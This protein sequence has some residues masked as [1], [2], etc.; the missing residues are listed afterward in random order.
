MGD[1][2]MLQ[3]RMRELVS[4]DICLAF[5]GGVDSSLLLKVAAD[6]A[7]ETGKKVYAVTFDSRLHPSCDLRIARQVAG[8]LGGIHQVM[9]VDELEQ[10]EIRMN[11]VNRCYL[12]K[13]HLFMTLKKLAGEKGVRRILDGTNEDDMHV[14][15][16][17]IR[18]L[19]ELGII[20]PLAELHITK[21]AVKGM[22][23]E[24]GISVASRPS[25]PCMATRLPYNTRIDYDVLD[26]IAQGEA[27]L[28]DALPG[29]V[30]L[31]LHGGIARL[32]V[33][34]EAFAR[35]LDRRA[36]VVRRL[37]GLGFT[38][39]TLDLEGFRSG[40]M[41]VGITEVHGSADPSGGVPL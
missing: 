8:E 23:S 5:S 12:C 36:D 35:L 38:Y 13:R 37:K 9:E 39:V 15:R 40:S 33:D 29:N 27:Y 10:E 25:T 3:A 31:R 4:E 6:A 2:E 24:Y 32:E 11:P 21:E 20:S 16:P 18:A 30:R 22:A 14:Y 19:K 17:G 41:D 7:A 1:R 34:N 28:R 26:R